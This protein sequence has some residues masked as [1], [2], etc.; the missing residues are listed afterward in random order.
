MR[1]LEET[2]QMAEREAQIGALSA[3]IQGRSTVDAMLASAVSEL[4]RLLGAEQASIRMGL[5][6]TEAVLLGAGRDG[7]NG[8]TTG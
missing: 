3:K 2:R 4:G 6:E 1:L 7:D 5:R 8:E